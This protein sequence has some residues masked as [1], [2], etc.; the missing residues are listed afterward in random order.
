MTWAHRSVVPPQGRRGQVIS[1]AHGVL[2]N[3]Y[4]YSLSNA[5]GRK[6]V[7]TSHECVTTIA[8]GQPAK[9]PML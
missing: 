9:S 2:V 1:H 5:C 7:W 3:G 8:Q 6:V 4:S